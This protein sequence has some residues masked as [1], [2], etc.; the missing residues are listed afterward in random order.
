MF[1][2][3]QVLVRM[4]QGDSDRDLAKAGVVGRRKAGEIRDLA[5]EQGWLDA[6]KALPDDTEL[7]RLLA[8]RWEH[9]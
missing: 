8:R 7:A 3:R 9:A 6:D 4:R 1:E 2:L 5:R